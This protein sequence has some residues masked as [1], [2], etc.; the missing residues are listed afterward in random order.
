M[1]EA[2]KSALSVAISK[3]KGQIFNI[4][5]YRSQGGGCINEAYLVGNGTTQFFVKLNAASLLPMFEAEEAALKELSDAHAIRVPNPISEGIASNRSYLILEALPFGT[6]HS[7]SWEKMGRQLAQ[8]HRVTADRFG[9]HRN[10]VIG[11]THQHN[12]WTNDWPTFFREQ[13][14]RPQFEL[15]RQNGFHFPQAEEL[16]GEIESLLTGHSPSPSLL[17]GD[18]WSGNAGFLTDGTP[19]VFDP[20]AYYGDRE[21]DL[22][23]SEFF[24]G[25]P[26]AFYT[27]YE[28]EWPLTTGYEKRKDLYNLYHVLNHANLFGGGYASQTSS[29]ISN[30]LAGKP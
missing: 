18:L 9:W 12:N 6:A 16:L 26:A 28:R 29:M 30:L 24:G 13:R 25:F 8:L 1:N 15:A 7:G 14:L 3:K 2:L 4:S 17:H 10:N 22:A 27:A 23:F 21:T 5:D 20:A 19:V 11:S